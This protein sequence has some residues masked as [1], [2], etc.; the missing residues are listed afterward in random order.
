VKTFW[1]WTGTIFFALVFIFLT[2][3]GIGTTLPVDH[4]AWCT[5]AYRRSVPFLFAAVEADDTSVNWRSSI[6]SAV[7]LSGRG[8]SAVW[9]ETDA[10]GKTLTFRTLADD[11][12]SKLV[13]Q[14]DFEPGSAFAGTWTYMF[15]PGG[16]MAGHRRYNLTVLTITEDGQIYNPVFRFMGRYVVGYTQSMRT[17]LLDLGRMAAEQ[18]SVIC[19]Q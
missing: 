10:Y 15:L 4:H 6:K 5:A 8:P 16:L 3:A 12:K 1:R 13:R 7:L 17:Y 9:R 14:I 2:I 18:T 19:T 11:G